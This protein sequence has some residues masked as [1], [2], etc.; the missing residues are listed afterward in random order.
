MNSNVMNGY[1]GSENGE[2]LGYVANDERPESVDK[3]S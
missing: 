1:M 3:K 2:G